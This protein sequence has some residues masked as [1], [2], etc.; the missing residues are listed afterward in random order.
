MQRSTE[1]I[2]TTHTGSLP[3]P[4]D[5]AA[6]L[7][8][9]DAGTMPDPEA[10]HDRVCR[11][12]AEVVRQ[13]AEAGVDILNDG[14]QGKVGYSTYVRHRLTGFDGTSTVSVRSDWADFPEAAARLGSSPTVSRPACNVPA[15]KRP[16]TFDSQVSAS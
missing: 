6:T 15:M 3:R 10:F 9:L 16:A 5:L 7:E 13:Q 14:E 4:V 8:A 1:R 12:V 2:L 11:A